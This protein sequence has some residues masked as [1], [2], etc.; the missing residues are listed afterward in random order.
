VASRR[1]K[2][3]SSPEAE[4]VS[5]ASN[6][7][8]PTAAS[9]ASTPTTLSPETSMDEIAD[10]VNRIRVSVSSRADAAKDSHLDGKRIQI[11]II[12]D[13]TTIQIFI[14]KTIIERYKEKYDFKLFE[15]GED[16]LEEIKNRR[17]SGEKDFDV[18]YV[19]Q[20]LRYGI[21]GSE[22]IEKVREFYPNVPVYVQ[23]SSAKD[24]EGLK[25]LK[26]AFVN[27]NVRAIKDKLN[28]N[29]FERSIKEL[30]F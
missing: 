2:Q 12:E 18:I 11:L 16:A 19:D 17:Q 5:S 30:N 25:S 7:D 4:G 22:T 21:S 28:K 3:S 14:K 27:C 26:E 8:T 10:A 29:D 20:K 9:D 1:Y 23:S 15:R 6:T 24:A 13:T